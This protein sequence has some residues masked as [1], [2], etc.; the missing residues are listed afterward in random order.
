MATNKKMAV[1][2]KTASL[3]H[4]KGFEKYQQDFARVLLPEEEYT[5]EEAKE[6]L[7]KYFEKKKEGK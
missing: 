2:Y 7:D 6:I 4:S 5:V 3:I 1:K